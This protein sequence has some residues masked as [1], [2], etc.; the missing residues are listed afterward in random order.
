MTKKTDNKQHHDGIFR[1]IYSHRRFALDIFRLILGPEE[2]DLFD[3]RTLKS[4]MTVYFGRED[5]RRQEVDLVFQVRLK[6]GADEMGVVFLA[7]HKSR[8]DCGVFNQLLR[9][10]SAMYDKDRTPILPILVYN[11]KVPE[12]GGAMRF[13]DCLEGMT[14]AVCESF[15]RDILDFGV[16]LLN[17]RDM[18]SWQNKKSLTSA[19]IL[20]LMSQIWEVSEGI[21]RE[22]SDRCEKLD[23]ETKNLFMNKGTDYAHTH[24]PK[25]IT[26]SVVE[27]IGGKNMGPLSTSLERE[28]TE[29]REE[30]ERKGRE[31]GKKEIA[32]QMLEDGETIA[33]VC[34]YTGLTEKE[35]KALEPKRAA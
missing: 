27:K 17:I 14:A 11:G 26:Y 33:K 3:W 9:Y 31:E 18:S 25:V 20:Y 16:R 35:V 8:K 1:D 32:L 10:Q 15:G 4:K 30:G 28:R 7:E 24:N 23:E 21:L 6:G 5:G 2:F 13:Q 19:P 29:G 22:F 12:W 34:K